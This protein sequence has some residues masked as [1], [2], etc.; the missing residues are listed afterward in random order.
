MS[1]D[2]KCQVNVMLYASVSLSSAYF[3]KEQFLKILG[4]KDKL[5]AKNLLSEWISYA[6]NCG[7]KPF[8]NCAN[9]MI[10]WREGILNSFDFPFTNGFT[11]GCNNKIK[12]L[13]RNAFGYR[14]FKR[15]CNR[16]LHMFS[17]QSLRKQGI[18]S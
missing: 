10:R 4:C 13:K 14:N 3:L 6:L 11:E 17:Y 1:D 12:V 2:Q 8:E 16:I 18:A 7:I 15:F 9:T 5:A